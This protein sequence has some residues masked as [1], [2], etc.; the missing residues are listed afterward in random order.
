MASSSVGVSDAVV[1]FRKRDLGCHECGFEIGAVF[2]D[3]EEIL[4]V[5][6]GRCSPLRE[7]RIPGRLPGAGDR[8]HSSGTLADASARS[9]SPGQTFSFKPDLDDHAAELSGS[10][11]WAVTL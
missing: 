1:P 5:F 2:E 11:G 7:N 3:S 10:G 4:A 6:G 8:R 9:A